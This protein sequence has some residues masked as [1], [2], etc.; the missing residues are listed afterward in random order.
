MRAADAMSC[1]TVQISKGGSSNLLNFYCT[2]YTT[3]YTGG[4]PA[5]NP[6]LA[7]RAQPSQCCT[8]EGDRLPPIAAKT[9]SGYTHNVRPYVEYD[10]NVDEGD[11]FRDDDH[12]STQSKLSYS[13]E[14]VQYPELPIPRKT[15]LVDT[16]F[17]ED[18]SILLKIKCA[19]QSSKE[20][21]TVA[22]ADY[23]PVLSKLAQVGTRSSHARRLG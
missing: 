7:I 8:K 3:T 20:W 18:K 22:K 10:K 4:K 9:G 16:G 14:A 2:Q 19:P 12:Y 21:K 1:P 5:R 11:F 17:T 23:T 6:R 13:Q 15:H